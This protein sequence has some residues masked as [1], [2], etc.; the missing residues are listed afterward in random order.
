MNDHPHEKTVIKSLSAA[1]DGE[2]LI[3][4]VA[5]QDSAPCRVSFPRG[6]IEHIRETG[7]EASV[8][9][10]LSGMEIALALPQR[11]AVER[12][13]SPRAAGDVDLT[14]QAVAD[15]A[16]ASA[17]NAQAAGGIETPKEI[18]F[19]L[20]VR[21]RQTLNYQ[22]F[23]FKESDVHWGGVVGQTDGKNGPYTSLPLKSKIGPFG[24]KEIIFDMKKQLF[25]ELY[26]LAKKERRDVLNLEEETRYSPSGKSPK[27]PVRK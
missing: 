17:F 5:M 18:R 21:S 27:P 8:I 11:A 9:R 12:I 7:A 1:R 20:F 10:L 15:I 22:L 13:Y 24:E 26:L 25:M 3:H 23:Q 6:A 19:S 16:V 2:V 4:A 14:A